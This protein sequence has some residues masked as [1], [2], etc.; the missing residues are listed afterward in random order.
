MGLFPRRWVNSGLAVAV[1]V[2]VAFEVVV[3]A[4][5]RV[6]VERAVT[7]TRVGGPRSSGSPFL[8]IFLAKQKK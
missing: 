6:P 3:A 2:A 1:A 5:V 8:V 4:A 7:A